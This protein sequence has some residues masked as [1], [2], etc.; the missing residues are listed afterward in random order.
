MNELRCCG[1]QL[2][3][4]LS[5]RIFWRPPPAP[6]FLSAHVTT[7]LSQT[8]KFYCRHFSASRFRMSDT[9][10]WTATVV[11]KQFLD[12]FEEKGHTIGMWR[13]N[14]LT[15]RLFSST[16]FSLGLRRSI[17]V[18]DD[19]ALA[20]LS[21]ESHSANMGELQ[22]PRPLWSPTMT[23]PSSLPMPV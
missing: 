11:R 21:F 1:S 9:Q 20:L 4:A 18:P 10:K 15:G 12:F 13:G 17:V 23:L 6:N 7:P 16:D 2:R 19:L 3:L 8:P 14:F 22:C 5:Q